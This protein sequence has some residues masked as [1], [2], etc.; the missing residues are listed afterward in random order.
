MSF[1]WVTIWTNGLVY[2]VIST[3]LTWS[4]KLSRLPIV[5]CSFL[6][7]LYFAFLT[8]L[9]FLGPSMRSISSYTFLGFSVFTFSLIVFNISGLILMYSSFV[10]CALP[11][12]AGAGGSPRYSWL[13]TLCVIVFF[14]PCN[15]FL[16]LRRLRMLGI[17]SPNCHNSIISRLWFN[18][19]ENSLF[20]SLF[21]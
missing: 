16:V 14:D 20:L 15:S 21:F 8:C 19:N 12:H 4:V 6:L 1:V 11:W 13:A 2:N 18:R 3:L 10:F 17:I 9:E 7:A 5:C